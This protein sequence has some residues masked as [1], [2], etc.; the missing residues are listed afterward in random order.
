[1]AFLFAGVCVEFFA[2]IKLSHS[3]CIS[4]DMCDGNSL[5]NNLFR[6]ISSFVSILHYKT[7]ASFVPYIQFRWH[8]YT[9][10][11][12][13]W[14]VNM[15]LWK[16]HTLSKKEIKMIKTNF[17][18]KNSK[19]SLQSIWKHHPR[20]GLCSKLYR[21]GENILVPYCQ[22]NTLHPPVFLTSKYLNHFVWHVLCHN[23]VELLIKRPTIFR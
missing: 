9:T 18:M 2:G 16:F 8:L 21:D 11:S 22:M 17:M 14:L 13:F 5:C 1:M 23:S 19:K 15:L 7:L 20:L 6:F 10:N 12:R 4:P 3:L